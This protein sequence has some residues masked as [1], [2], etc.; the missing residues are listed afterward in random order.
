MGWDTLTW[1][2]ESYRFLVA[3]PVE[4]ALRLV[5][6]VIPLSASAGTLSLPHTFANGTP[7]DA[8]QVNANFA[9]GQA[10]VNDNDGRIS[11]L[12]S[13]IQVNADAI[14]DNAAE[15]DSHT[16]V[17]PTL[18]VRVD[19]SCPVG[20][21]IRAVSA[22][23]TVNCELDSDTTYG[24]GAGIT[25][26]GGSFSSDSSVV[27][28]RVSDGCPVGESIRAIASDG[29][30]TCEMGASVLD[31]R[32]FGAQPSDCD[33]EGSNCGDD[34]A[35][36][37][38][39]LDQLAATTDGPTQQEP[40]LANPRI[41]IPSGTY[42]ISQTLTVP[43]SASWW[44]LEGDGAR[45]SL[46]RWTGPSGIPMLKLVNANH[47]VLRDFGLHG[48]AGAAPS[49]GIQ[50][51]SQFPRSGGAAPKRVTIQRVFIGN[52]Y[53]EAIENGISF[54]A[55]NDG[56]T[57]GVPLWD[58]NNEQAHVIDVEIANV[59]Q[60]GISIEH[61]NSLNHKIIGGGIVA[62]QACIN[63][64]R[65]DNTP[66]G[67]FQVYGTAFGSSGVLFRVGP[68]YYPNLIVGGADESSGRILETPATQPLWS[69][70]PTETQ[71]QFVGGQYKCGSSETEENACVV[72]D[73]AENSRLILDG[74]QVYSANGSTWYFPNQ[75]PASSLGSS[76]QLRSIYTNIT[77]LVYGTHVILHDVHNVSQ[78]PLSVD[79]NPSL[80]NLGTGRL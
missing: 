29:T 35:A 16:A 78:I 80:V 33:L 42:H 56:L 34:T 2:R 63:N 46:L 47:V 24:A 73:A 49:H 7:A 32:D 71:L 69:G 36:F 9:A 70:S 43:N 54:T 15:L 23:G 61:S 20:Q 31:V 55:E 22:D 52:L 27:Q 19:G 21:S 12:E 4:A 67:S 65:S 37:Q 66:G 51:H 26:S 28:L 77:S 14:S 10:A 50:V 11:T 74:T 76:V 68:S 39:A 40:R 48:N 3:N 25:L 64:V 8:D 38:S 60:Y 30:V 13:G 6:A 53:G 45:A 58:G 1:F 17:L 57:N 5:L 75:E 44:T 59:S 72:F 79:G 41:Y 62:G 18:Q